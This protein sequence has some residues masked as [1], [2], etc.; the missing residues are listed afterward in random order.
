MLYR[1]ADKNDIEFLVESRLKFIEIKDGNNDFD[2]IRS[3]CFDY[4]D[5]A[6]SEDMCDCILVEADGVC[7]GTGI[8]FYYSSVPSV[9]NPKGKNAYITS[10][11]VNEEYRCQGIGTEVVRRLINEANDKGFSIIMLNASE[12]GKSLYYKLGFTDIKNGMILNTGK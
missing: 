4:F 10:I 11:Y 12:E 3:N 1:L 6:L 7:V 5:K 9:S 8:V 2:L